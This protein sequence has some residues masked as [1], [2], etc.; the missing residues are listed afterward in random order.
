MQQ[1]SLFKANQKSAEDDTN[2]EEILLKVKLE[3]AFPHLTSTDVLRNNYI[4]IR[5]MSFYQW[6]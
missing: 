4:C 3:A 6:S 1:K 2:V 5:V